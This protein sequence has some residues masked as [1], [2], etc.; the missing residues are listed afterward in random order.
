MMNDELALK[1]RLGQIAKDEFRV[2][3]D[4]ERWTLA[5]T[6]TLFIGSPDSELRD[7]LI[8]PAFYTWILKHELFTAVQLHQLLDLA[9]DEN[10]LFYRLGEK[11]TDAVFTRSFSALL[12]PLLLIAHRK[13]PFLTQLEIVNLKET[14]IRYLE[15]EQDV[16]GYVGEKGWAHAVAHAADAL[17]DLALCQEL[18]ADDL[19][20]ILAAIQQKIGTD[21]YVFVHE[22]DE[23]MGTAV[24]SLLS[25][26]ALDETEINDW[27]RSFIPFVAEVEA[28]PTSSRYLNVKNFLRSLYFRLYGQEEYEAICPVIFEVVRE[29]GRFK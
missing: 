21:N 5:L 12:L 13:R 29:I 22:E 14:V 4:A 1:E 23:R 10:H 2:D 8:Y 3:S 17:D 25:R 15:L 7:G 27:I 28:G 16:R 24:T 19:R 20:D 6:M 18:G 11:G 26:Q 9:I